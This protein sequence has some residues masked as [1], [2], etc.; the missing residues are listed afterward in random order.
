MFHLTYRKGHWDLRKKKL[1]S[2]EW[3]LTVFSVKSV[4]YILFV[5]VFFFFSTLLVLALFFERK[6]RDS[7]SNDIY[8]LMCVIWS[9]RKSLNL[10]LNWKYCHDGNSCHGG[11][12]YRAKCVCDQ[13]VLIVTPVQ[14]SLV[15]FTPALQW[16]TAPSR[17]L[18]VLHFS[19]LKG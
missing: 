18:C 11:I 9:I 15:Y 13:S 10:S 12:Y 2:L 6:S 16:R 17:W 19:V 5:S 7:V 3:S 1:Q 8:L 14:S 4:S